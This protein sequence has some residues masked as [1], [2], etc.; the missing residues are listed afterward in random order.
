MIVQDSDE[1]NIR[2]NS[3][4]HFSPVSLRMVGSILGS[5]FSMGNDLVSVTCSSTEYVIEDASSKC[6]SGSISRGCGRP[7]KTKQGR[8]YF[9]R[10]TLVVVSNKLRSLSPL[11]VWVVATIKG[12]SGVGSPNLWSSLVLVLLGIVLI[13]ESWKDLT[14]GMLGRIFNGLELLVY[15]RNLWSSCFRGSH[16]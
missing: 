2:A 15:R 12:R 10:R 5:C 13:M 14:L 6:S 4:T 11:A 1:P 16:S 9:F 3:H 7:K 8:R